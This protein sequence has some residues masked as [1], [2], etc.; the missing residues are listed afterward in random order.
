MFFFFLLVD[1]VVVVVWVLYIFVRT[2]CD[3]CRY[4]VNAF[5]AATA[6]AYFFIQIFFFCWINFLL[7]SCCSVCLLH[8]FFSGGRCC[9]ISLNSIF[10]FGT[11]CLSSSSDYE[12][13]FFFLFLAS[14]Y[15]SKWKEKLLLRF[16]SLRTCV[17]CHR[18][19]KQRQTRITVP[20]WFWCFVPFSSFFRF[21]GVEIWRSEKLGTKV[22]FI[23][24]VFWLG[25]P[26]LCFAWILSRFE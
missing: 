17:Q 23:T 26:S 20:I 13:K 7:F 10:P 3:W 8:F 9:C 21:F 11:R 15:S 25:F 18:M 2:E 16:D 5:D 19:N 22:F 12:K 4:C 14:L 1:V 24:H 6:G